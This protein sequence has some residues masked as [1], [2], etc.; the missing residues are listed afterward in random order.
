ML[1]THNWK[2]GKVEEMGIKEKGMNI[3]ENVAEGYKEQRRGRRHEI[4]GK[5]KRK[6][7][8]VLHAYVGNAEWE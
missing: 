3:K 7:N 4:K 5:G 6:P 2:E 8:T 1:R